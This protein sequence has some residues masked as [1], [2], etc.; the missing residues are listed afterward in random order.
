MEGRLE[1][2]FNIFKGKPNSVEAS[3]P[4]HD[5]LDTTGPVVYKGSHIIID[6]NQLPVGGEGLPIRW[7][8]GTSARVIGDGKGGIDILKDNK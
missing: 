3:K 8:D 5:S 1:R 6:P 2:L 4:Q 7:L